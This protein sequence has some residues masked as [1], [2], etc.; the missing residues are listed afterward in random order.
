VP[1]QLRHSRESVR[2][3]S[4]IAFSLSQQS[5]L[6]KPLSQ[7][8]ETAFSAVGYYL[9]CH[10][11]RAQWYLQLSA[12]RLRYQA[13]KLTDIDMRFCPFEDCGKPS[14]SISVSPKHLLHRIDI[15]LLVE[16]NPSSPQERSHRPYKCRHCERLIRNLYNT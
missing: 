13:R 6:S 1:Y 11:R 12:P 2:S 10:G 7:L 9:P 4:R 5:E 15:S 8:E 3:P 14:S 16:R